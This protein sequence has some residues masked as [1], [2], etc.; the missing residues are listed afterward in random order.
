M[1][2]ENLVAKMRGKFRSS[3]EIIAESEKNL[4]K[5]TGSKFDLSKIWRFFLR[6]NTKQ[7]L[8][9][10]NSKDLIP[11]KILKYFDTAP[12]GESPSNADPDI[13]ACKSPADLSEDELRWLIHEL[14]PRYGP[15]EVS[16][17]SPLEKVLFLAHLANPNVYDMPEYKHSCP[18]IDKR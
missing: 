18:E 11:V 16:F 8:A 13:I 15:E 5:P 4:Q 14:G 3:T 9:G 6:E 12:Q 1:S 7:I 2:F 10:E 17:P